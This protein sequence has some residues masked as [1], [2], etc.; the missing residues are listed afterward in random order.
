MAKLTVKLGDTKKT[1]SATEI[2]NETLEGGLCA[3]TNT[4]L[5]SYATCRE[6]GYG[7][8]TLSV[9]YTEEI[10][11][12][13]VGYAENGVP[14]YIE[15]AD[16]DPV[17][18]LHSSIK[19]MPD[20]TITYK[21]SGKRGSK[22]CMFQDMDDFVAFVNVAKEKLPLIKQALV[23]AYAEMQSAETEDEDSD[24]EE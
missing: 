11:K 23:E 14:K 2:F 1:Q 8:Q 5:I 20:G 21:Q 16:M 22:S 12:A 15:S 9:D 17:Q 4:L 24:S 18:A 6:Q 7:S 3:D 10:I 13:L 19:M